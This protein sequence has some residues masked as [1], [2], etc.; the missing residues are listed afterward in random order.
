MKDSPKW[1]T[2]K[3]CFGT[4]PE[5]QK[6]SKKPASK[7]ATEPKPTTQVQSFGED[8]IRVNSYKED[9]VEIKPADR[10]VPEQ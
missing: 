6:R 10:Q 4:L 3:D 5:S 2:I 8:P 7:A 9:A 1:L